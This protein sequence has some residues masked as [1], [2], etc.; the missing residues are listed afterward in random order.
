M[1]LPLICSLWLFATSS[2]GI[3]YSNN[4]L[5]KDE[6]YEVHWRFENNTETFYFKVRAKA[7]GWIGFGVSRLLWPENETLRWNMYSMR[8]YDV[9]VGGV[10]DSGKKYFKDFMTNGH[11]APKE[12]GHADWNVSNII[13]SNGTTTMEFSRK[14]DTGDANDDNVIEPGLRRMVC[15]YHDTVDYNI[16]MSKFTKHTWNGYEDIEFIE[17]PKEKAV[18]AYRATEPPTTGASTLAVSIVGHLLLIVIAVIFFY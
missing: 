16:S 6:N 14:K 12:D 10:D 8:H 1:F 4:S 5:C 15:A 3:E 18:L 9:L 11:V 17:K 2:S 7:T 13:E